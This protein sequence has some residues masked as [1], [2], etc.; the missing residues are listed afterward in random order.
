MM[1]P[2]LV[3]IIIIA[4]RMIEDESR[5]H[6]RGH[7]GVFAFHRFPNHLVQHEVIGGI[8]LREIHFGGE[9]RA[10]GVGLVARG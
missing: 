5:A 9:L 8:F 2:T 1:A 4:L 7:D 3:I 10:G 6:G